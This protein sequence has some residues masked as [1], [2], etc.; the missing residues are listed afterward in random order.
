MNIA[1]VKFD[2]QHLHELIEE[3]DKE[4]LERYPADEIF[5]VD[6]TSPSVKDMTFAVGY[7]DDAP[8]ACGALRPLN[9]TE[10]E[11]KRFYVRRAHRKKG[12][13]TALLAFLEG[14]AK[15]SAYSVMKLETGPMQPESICLYE[16]LGY[17]HIGRYG[18]YVDC[19]SSVCME[20]R[21]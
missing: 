10:V 8:I 15:S 5:G 13:A 4:L 6:F 19:D 1:I 18:E 17:T 21:L 16:K 3:L 11:L 9:E 7:L 12:A 2:H 20:K 14:E